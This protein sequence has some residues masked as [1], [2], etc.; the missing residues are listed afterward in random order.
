MWRHKHT[1]TQ[2]NNCIFKTHWPD[3]RLLKH[4]HTHIIISPYHRQHHFIRSHFGSMAPM[5]PSGRF[6]MLNDDATFLEPLTAGSC[7]PNVFTLK[8]PDA[9][10][11]AMVRASVGMT[12]ACAPNPQTP[13]L[14]RLPSPGTL[15]SMMPMLQK[16]L[17]PSVEK[18]RQSPGG[19]STSSLV[20]PPLLAAPALAPS[21]RQCER[22]VIPPS[23]PPPPE[24][25]HSDQVNLFIIT[26][27]I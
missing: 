25:Q 27:I 16:A 13:G 7:E 8:A 23:T 2:R 17:V 6:G 18:R 10:L 12:G 20:Q 22:A 1:K 21:L 9:R 11:S 19:S 4:H 24:I 15:A 5:A 14:P 3:P 26:T